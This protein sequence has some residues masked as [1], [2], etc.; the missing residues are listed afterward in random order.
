MRAASPCLPPPASGPAI[1]S[2][3]TTHIR[4]I[5][6]STGLR[7][8]RPAIASDRVR[9]KIVG[10]HSFRLRRPRGSPLGTHRLSLERAMVFRARAPFRLGPNPTVS[11]RKLS[12]LLRILSASESVRCGLASHRSL[13]F[14]SLLT[15][16]ARHLTVSPARS[17]DPRTTP[18][19]QVSALRCCTTPRAAR[20]L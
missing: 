18:R 9:S 2:T 4:H 12:P 20:A 13:L 17:L 3:G 7:Q 8:C 5:T 16:G 10:S 14:G 19:R 15:S 11:P 6:F 1:V